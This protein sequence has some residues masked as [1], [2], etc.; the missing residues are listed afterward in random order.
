MRKTLLLLLIFLLLGCNKLDN[1]ETDYYKYV[2]NII[3][4]DKKI[5]NM[6][7]DGYKL[8]LP[9]GINIKKSLN[10]NVILS[11]EDTLMYL[12]VDI[13]SYY[14][15]K[16]ILINDEGYDYFKKIDGNNGYLVVDENNGKYYINIGYNYSNIEFFCE[17]KDISKLLT[18]S[19]IILNNIDFNKSIIEKELNNSYN[20]SGEKIY[21]INDL[22]D[23]DSNFSKYLNEY[24]EEVEE[25]E[26]LPD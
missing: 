20:N 24:V 14:Y 1:Y 7:F 22:K 18:F 23:T 10:N 6:S 11:S 9:K 12:Y 19:S 26:K 2:K 15:K 3:D 5:T 13:I 21:E 16:D 25:K 17:K 4:N 8:Y